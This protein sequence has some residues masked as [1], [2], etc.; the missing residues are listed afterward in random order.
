L[1]AARP[2]RG[3]SWRNIVRDLHPI[4]NVAAVERARRPSTVVAPIRHRL[5]KACIF[6]A[7][8]QVTVIA[9]DPRRRKEIT[10]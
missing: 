9:S 3:D 4:I 5:R 6:P 2:V 1:R 8:L 10:A 7:M